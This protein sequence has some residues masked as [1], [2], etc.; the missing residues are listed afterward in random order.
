MFSVAKDKAQEGVAAGSDDE[1]YIDAILNGQNDVILLAV[2]VAVTNANAK[3]ADD[4]S[5]KTG[6][7]ALWPH[8]A[9]AWKRGNA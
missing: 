2:G 4:A 5:L 8:Y 9:A 3:T 7:T 1:A 6:V